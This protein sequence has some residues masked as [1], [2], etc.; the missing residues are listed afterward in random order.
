MKTIVALSAMLFLA[1]CPEKPKT[2]TSGNDQPVVIA[3]SDGRPPHDGKVPLPGTPI[4]IRHDQKFQWGDTGFYVKDTG[5]SVACFDFAGQKPKP[6]SS[7]W[8]VL[9]NTLAGRTFEM[10]STDQNEI[11][12]NFHDTP[13][14]LQPPGVISIP[15][16]VVTSAIVT[17]GGGSNGKPTTYNAV[18]GTPLN[19]Y[20]HY[21]PRDGCATDPCK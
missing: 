21:C 19:F 20:V 13:V 18:T 4:N 1:A 9:F 7:N 11:D 8:N 6:N 5:F 2:Q 16:D 3:D 10:S 14:T 15:G 17:I 12:F